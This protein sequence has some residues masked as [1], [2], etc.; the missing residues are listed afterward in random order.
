MCQFF[1]SPRNC[2]ELCCFDWLLVQLHYLLRTIH[3]YWVANTSYLGRDTLVLQFFYFIFATKDVGRTYYKRLRATALGY[4][5]VDAIFY[6]FLFVD[7]IRRV[8][9][10]NE[11][12][13]TYLVIHI[14]LRN[15][16]SPIRPPDNTFSKCFPSSHEF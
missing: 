8:D 4:V 9:H 12:C 3:F 7:L 14:E 2:K 6:F 16:P 10:L 13:V 15:F 1:E 5:G 11:W